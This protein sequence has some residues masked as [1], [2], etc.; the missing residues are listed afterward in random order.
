MPAT[1]PDSAQGHQGRLAS[2]RPQLLPALPSRGTARTA[3]RQI[4]ES[5]GFPL[6]RAEAKAGGMKPASRTQILLSQLAAVLCVGLGALGFV[7]YGT[8]PE[9]TGRFWG[10]IASRLHE[11]LRFRFILQPTMAALLALHDGIADAGDH[12]QPYLRAVLTIPGERAQRLSEGFLAV[13]RVLLLGLAM[14]FVYQLYV[15][16]TFYPGETAAVALLLAFIPYL[17]LRGPFTRVARAIL[18]RKSHSPSP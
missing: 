7:W 11:P 2:V 13:S 17:R 5:S 4:D 9:V 14:D 3:D 6:R 18:V 8:G 16:K 15:L 10:D 12:R 1:D